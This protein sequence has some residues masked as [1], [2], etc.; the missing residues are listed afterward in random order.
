M[1]AYVLH[2]ARKNLPC[3]FSQQLTIDTCLSAVQLRIILGEIT[4]KRYWK[5]Q[6][7]VHSIQAGYKDVQVR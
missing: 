4:Y 3:Y 5:S 2:H 6:R 1:L 7:S